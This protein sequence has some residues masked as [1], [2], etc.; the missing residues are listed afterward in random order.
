MP[1]QLLTRGS[2]Q[3][4]GTSVARTNQILGVEKCCVN[5]MQAPVL[6]VNEIREVLARVVKLENAIESLTVSSHNAQ[7][8]Q[9]NA[10]QSVKGDIELLH[11]EHRDLQAVL[12][13]NLNN[14]RSPLLSPTF[15][16]L[17]SKEP[18][19]EQHCGFPQCTVKLSAP[20]RSCSAAQSL[21]HMIDCP[22]CPDGQR[23][24]HIAQ[25]ML[26]FQ[27]SPRVVPVDVCCWCGQNFETLVTS[28]NVDTPDAR[29]RHRKS[30]Q[31]AVINRLL[32]PNDHV[33]AAQMLADTWCIHA[34][35]VPASKRSRDS[36]PPA[37]AAARRIQFNAGD[38]FL[39]ADLLVSSDA[40]SGND[41]ADAQHQWH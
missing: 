2:K 10:I 35:S 25:H 38:E 28:P 3:C 22:H 37:V 27:K 20:N 13:T 18:S 6:I 40:F 8:H 14:S 15:S 17:S 4:S 9:W 30:C 32:D 7:V 34:D 21:R 5:N 11:K 31:Q 16:P 1:Q 33:A 36:T 39:N 41:D 24:L 29:S 23:F 26:K 12:Q 19:P